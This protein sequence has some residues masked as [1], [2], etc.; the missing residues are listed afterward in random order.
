MCGNFLPIL[1]LLN[2]FLF[3]KAIKNKFI[4]NELKGII[5]NIFSIIDDFFLC[6]HK[7]LIKLENYEHGMVYWTWDKIRNIIRWVIFQLSYI[8][9]EKII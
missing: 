2:C 3:D 4:I 6:D 7:S 8:H 5:K 1:F 9:I